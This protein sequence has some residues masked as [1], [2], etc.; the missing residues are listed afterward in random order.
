[1]SVTFPREALE[2]CPAAE[3]ASQGARLGSSIDAPLGETYLALVEDRVHVVTRASSSDPFRA[4]DLEVDPR[5]DLGHETFLVL[6]LKSGGESKL[7]VGFTEEGQ[8]ARVIAALASARALRGLSAAAVAKPASPAAP[9]LLLAPASAPEPA[10]GAAALAPW[11]A[12]PAP[13]PA[14]PSSPFGEIQVRDVDPKRKMRSALLDV[15]Y[16]RTEQLARREDDLFRGPEDR[17]VSGRVREARDR[18]ATGDD[19]R[20]SI[21]RSAKGSRWALVVLVL[22]LAALIAWLL[23]RR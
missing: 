6:R 2:A 16:S 3:R 5:L 7:R 4:L 12:A 20:A 1:M 8:V 13:A 21:E 17:V 11:A 18:I 14:W 22:T 9:A 10:P 19:P 23:A 15:L